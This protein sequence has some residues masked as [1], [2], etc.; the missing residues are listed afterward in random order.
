METEKC[1]CI[2]TKHREDLEYKKLIHRLN[3]VEGQVRGVK[4]M[5]EEERYCVDILNQVAAIQS[6]LNAFNRELLTNHIKT[7]VVD[8]IKEGDEQVVDELCDTIRKLMK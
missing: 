7:C 5:V 4:T 8:D 1:C 6:A 3:R 2:K